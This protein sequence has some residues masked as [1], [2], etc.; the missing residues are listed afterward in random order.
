M[1]TPT[2]D[3]VSAGTYIIN[4]ARRVNLRPSLLY[5]AV[6]DLSSE[7][8]IT[9]DCI[10]R[11]AGILLYD[12]GLP[13]YFFETITTEFLKRIL[14]A[15]AKSLRVKE[16]GVDLSPWVA[17]IDFGFVENSQAQ[18]VRIATAETRQAMEVLLDSQLVGHRRE[19]YFNPKKEYYT[20]VFRS[21]TVLDM[22]E[23][24][25][26]ESRFLFALDKDYVQTPRL[27]RNRYEMF[28]ETVEDEVTP[29]I[30]ASPLADISE[31]RF[32][33][34]SDFEK[35][36]MGVLRKLFADHGLTITRA[37]WEPY[38]TKAG[39]PSSICS[40]YATGD[41][42]GSLEKLII[43]DLRAF[44]SF[45][46]SEI[47]RLY[48][49]GRLNFRQML[50]AGNAVDFTHMF[51]FKERGNHSDKEIMDSLENAD[52]KAALASRIH[53]SNKFTYVSRKIMD[54]A[55]AHPDLIK[56]LFKTV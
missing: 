24:K 56:F 19:Y 14:S 45:R 49:D 32:M 7:G 4:Q 11:A 46:V 16:D 3:P 37:Y 38:R 55:C 35:P 31:T 33:F 41:L 34:N 28:L 43:D 48:V 20:Y 52:H 5:E 6:I 1:N 10:N 54:T 36:Q 39:V 25:L 8:L 47:T 18:R 13:S 53:E 42:S 30:A 40:V 23:E 15:I 9:A 51:I 21:E 44:L 27:T 29:L 50:F 17:D 26:S 12:L 22:P 2:S